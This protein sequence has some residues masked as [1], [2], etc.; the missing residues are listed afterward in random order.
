MYV[1][2][3]Y[4]ISPEICLYMPKMF[5]TVVTVQMPILLII[6]KVPAKRIIHNLIVH[7]CVL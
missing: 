6:L 4:R 7:V 1:V 2:R 5:Y 3:K